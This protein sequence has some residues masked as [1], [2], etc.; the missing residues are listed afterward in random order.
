MKQKLLSI[1][2]LIMSVTYGLSAFAADDWENALKTE[3]VNKYIKFNP[4]PFTI[5]FKQTYPDFNRI[6]IAIAKDNWTHDSG[7]SFVYN[8]NDPTEYFL[9]NQVGELIKFLLDRYD[10]KIM[11]EDDIVKYFVPV[12]SLTEIR[13][14]SDAEYYLFT[15]DTFF[16][17]K[18]G[19]ILQTSADGT[20]E[21][22][23]E[24]MKLEPQ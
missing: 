3:F 24:K 12:I 2:I 5:P 18:S 10:Y 16:D 20:V 9:Y 4:I 7:F 17:S 19:Y 8:K 14:I 1:F 23:E 13:K 21:N 15:G 6:K 22:I 11:N